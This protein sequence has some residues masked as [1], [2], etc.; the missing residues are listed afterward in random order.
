M[1]I[2]A[3]ILAALLFPRRLAAANDREVEIANAL[4][5]SGVF[6]IQQ[7]D[8]LFVP[9]GE[10][11]HAKGLQK[12]DAQSGEFLV[13]AFNSLPAKLGRIFTPGVP[14]YRGHPDV[15]GRADSNPA[16]P[17]M[18]WVSSVT[19]END[20]VRFA[21]KWNPDGEAAIS[22]AHYRFYSPNWLLRPVRGGIQPVKLLSIGLTNNPRIPVPAIANDDNPT[23]TMKLTDILRK[24]LGI[25]AENDAPTDEQIDAAATGVQTQLAT[26]QTAA[27]DAASALASA[28]H[29]AEETRILADRLAAERDAATGQL[30]AAK[31]QLATLTSQL[32]A[33]NDA[34]TAARTRFIDARITGLVEA[35]RVLPAERDTLRTE[36]LAIANDADLDTRLTALATAAP[37]LKTA[38]VTKDLGKGKSAL[39]TAANADEALR[40]VQRQE[41]IAGELKLIQAANSRMP[42]TTA[43]DLAFNRAAAKHPTLFPT[44]AT[45]AQA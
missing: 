31:S 29:T 16:A 25:P 8:T 44:K 30:T 3:S 9:Y 21:V 19:A 7:R 11:P 2:L 17:A 1:K 36:L 32:T 10:Y 35:T 27:N 33:A 4:D 22:N 18:G 23:D 41:A 34:A 14:I 40:S 38:A 6:E 20:G 43:Y 39:V 26:L 45:T 24:L 5:G 28:Q 37:K 13:A 12:F 15:P 42:E